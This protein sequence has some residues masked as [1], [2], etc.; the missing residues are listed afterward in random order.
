[1]TKSLRLALKVIGYKN[2]EI[3]RCLMFLEIVTASLLYTSAGTVLLR[4][5]Q[6]SVRTVLQSSGFVNDLGRLSNLLI[7][8]KFWMLVIF[9]PKNVPFVHSRYAGRIVLGSLTARKAKNLC[10]RK[11]PEKKGE[12]LKPF[13]TECSSLSIHI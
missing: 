1:M 6:K 7:H 4:P 11:Y 2:T 5:Q 10:Y 12:E 9:L 8:F 3:L 13:L